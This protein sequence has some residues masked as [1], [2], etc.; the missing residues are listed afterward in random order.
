M[1]L[2][3]RQRIYSFFMTHFNVP[4]DTTE[5]EAEILSAEELTVTPTG[6]IATFLGGKMIFDLNREET[7]PLIENLKRSRSEV[8]NH[9][10]IIRD[11][12]IEI[13]GYIVPGDNAEEPFI[14][15]RYQRDGYTVG[16]YAIR[17][18]GYYPIPFLLFVPDDTLKKHLAIIYLNPKGKAAD[19]KTG[20][21]IEKLVK[22][23]YIVAATDVLGIG[24]TANTAARG[25]TDGYTAVMIGRSVVAIQ[26]AD[27]VRMAKYL[28]RR[29]DTDPG[30]VGALAIGESCIP[31]IHAAAFD[32][33]ISNIILL[34]PLISFGSV[35]MNNRYRIGLSPREG[36]NYWHPHEID[37]SWGVGGALQGYDLPDLVGCIAPRKVIMA[38]IHNQMLEPASQEVINQELEFPQKAFAF[39]KAAENIR[40]TTNADHP[41][42]FIDWCFK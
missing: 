27:I 33:S 1:T 26:A 4:G 10:N 2:K 5:V 37:F 11:K 17:G 35:V 39:R 15:G 18:E 14:N 42:S 28:K 30:K 22:K 24:E 3:I 19:A 9:L 12:A 21:E 20:G 25:I 31:L 29:S 32:P 40:I 6:Q 41:D 34:R 36:G 23:G 38:D 13:S 8:E 7:I 16:K